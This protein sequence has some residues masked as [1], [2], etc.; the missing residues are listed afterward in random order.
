MEGRYVDSRSVDGMV[1]VLVNNANAVALAPQIIDDDNNSETPG[2]YE[3]RDEYIARVT[4][5][6]GQFVEGALP[7]YTTYGA[8][9]EMV[10]TGLL[11]LPEN[12]YQP[13]VAG[14]RSLISIV[15]FDS[16]S[17]EPGLV[18]TSGVYSTGASAIYAS[19]DNFYV[20]DQDSS[21]EDGATTRIVK[22]DWD[23]ATGGVDFIATTTVAGTILNQ[24]S[25]DEND[26]YLRIATTVSNNYSGNWS[27]RAENMLFVL[28]EDGGVFE[29]VG[30]LQNL[31]LNET[32]RSVRFLGDRAFVTTF[33]TIDPLFAIDL[34]D[35]E[36]PESVGHIT[37]PGFTSYMHL[38]DQN[39]LLTVGRNT[40]PGAVGPTQVSLF[41]IS[42]FTQPRRI[43]EYTFERFS[44]S[45]AELDHH[46]FG[47]YAEHGLL[48]M[49]VATPHVVR[50]DLDGDG[51]SETRRTI[52][53]NL[54]AVFT[55]DVN[56]ANPS[57]RLMLAGEI[58][59]GSPVRRSGYIGDKLYSIAGDSVKVVDVS[60][61]NSVIRELV[62]PPPAESEIFTIPYTILP[63]QEFSSSQRLAPAQTSPTPSE[64]DRRQALFARARADLAERLNIPEGA[65]LLV[66]AEAAPEAP[67]AGF[68]L[69]FRVGDRHVLYRVSDGGRV[70][71]VDDNFSF[72]SGAGAWHAVEPFTAPAPSG[73]AGD[74]DVN[75]R[76][77]S[78]DRAV[79]QASLGTWS[80]MTFL[81]ADGNRDGVVDAADY[82]IWRKNF[83]AASAVTSTGG[84]SSSVTSPK[85]PEPIRT[86]ASYSFTEAVQAEFST[87]TSRG[88]LARDIVLR[89]MKFVTRGDFN[90]SLLALDGLRDRSSQN[91]GG[92]STIDEREV[93]GDVAAIDRALELDF[94]PSLVAKR[95]Q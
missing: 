24:F 55:V 78:A 34:T 30:S 16:Q 25:A 13:L 68:H 65:A 86:T 38:V 89:Q 11:N 29:F 14:S 17:D 59:H 42:E 76:V 70:Q 31:A 53:E 56:A 21:R 23:P 90:A 72:N 62:I 50:V 41:D 85:P 12:I 40:P 10:R 81:A 87:A 63:I 46:A 49:P 64:N 67:G 73:I 54:L 95:N 28:R 26:G 52:V 47:Y 93:P 77:D 75:G 94:A 92:A 60:A 84:S 82:L 45:E 7:N 8:D 22:F 35:P 43:A 4:A 51:Y 19:H 83:G 58:D 88:P 18:D 44:T 5:N 74:Y 48:A 61:P 66:T 1:Y 32:M 33:R 2:R 15:S 69:V 20:F 3:T 57:A 37:L 27:Y 9:G 39:Y 79:W 6:P 36:S 80:L 71:L 91:S